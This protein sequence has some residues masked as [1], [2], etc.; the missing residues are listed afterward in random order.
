[1]KT[2]EDLSRTDADGVTTFAMKVGG[3][4]ELSVSFPTTDG[5]G[6]PAVVESISYSYLD[7]QPFETPLRL[8]LGT[9]P[10]DPSQITIELG[11]GVV[12]EELRSLGLP[13]P[14]DAAMWGT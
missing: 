2:V 10:I 14:P 1:P 3:E 6:E 12:A 7:G 11:S 5:S 9:A 4:V 13:K 8:G